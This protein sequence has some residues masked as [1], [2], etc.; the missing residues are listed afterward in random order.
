MKK[1]VPVIILDQAVEQVV[2]EGDRQKKQ[3]QSKTVAKLQSLYPGLDVSLVTDMPSSK[4]PYIL[5]CTVGG[6]KQETLVD[7]IMMRDMHVVLGM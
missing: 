3:N 6:V 5:L 4:V 2:T 7:M 1:K